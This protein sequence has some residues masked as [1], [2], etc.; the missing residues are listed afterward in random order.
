MDEWNPPES[1]KRKTCI[2][3][4]HAGHKNNEIKF[5]DQCSLNTVKT[6]RHELENCDGDYEAVARRKQHCRRS[7]CVCTAEFLENLQK[8]VLEESGIRIRAL[9]REL[10]VSSSTMRLA[11]NEDLHYHSYWKNQASELGL[12]HVN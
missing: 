6:I 2:M 12:C 3:M 8:K 9:S 10:N 11:I 1:W 7:D 5:A 4:T